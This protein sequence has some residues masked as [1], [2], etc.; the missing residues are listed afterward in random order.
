MF[1]I[2]QLEHFKTEITL[3]AAN[4]GHNYNDPHAAV[5]NA[6]FEL[7]QRIDEE[8]DCWIDE[9]FH[10]FIKEIRDDWSLDEEG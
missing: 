10:G 6:I 7:K 5:Q 3:T 4:D 8:F 2:S 1:D 9:N